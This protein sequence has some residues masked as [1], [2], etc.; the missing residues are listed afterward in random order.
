MLDNAVLALT[1]CWTMLARNSVWRHTLRS[2]AWPDP[3]TPSSDID[4]FMWRK[5]FDHNPLF[6]IAC[7]KIAAK[8]FALSRCPE[9]KTAEVLW[10]GNNSDEYPDAILTGDVVVKASSG[11]G[12]NLMIRDGKFDRAGMRATTSKWMQRRYGVG[13]GEWAYQVANQCLLVER[14]LL[15]DG[16]PIQSE[17]KF[18]VSD[19]R[20]IYVFAKRLTETGEVETA[21]F[22]REGDV[23]AGRVVTNPTEAAIAPPASFERMKRIAEALAASFDYMRIDL[24][25]ID[26]EIYFSE[27]TCY[28]LSGR[29][30]SD[31]HLR[32]LRNCAWDI[33]NSWFLTT[34]AT[35]LARSL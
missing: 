33:R 5:I 24:Y 9:L 32:E 34:L 3:V 12:R 31:S 20:M 10:R 13:K 22:N 8:D 27:L 25:E 30:G 19:G 1:R 4:K 14:M 35:W 7:D 18:H 11:C 16:R 2:G 17:Y 23:F 26:G 15:E 21:Y 6:A 28:P 29:G